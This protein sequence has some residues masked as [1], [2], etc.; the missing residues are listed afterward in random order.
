MSKKVN[1]KFYAIHFINDNENVIT[2]SWTECQELT[3]GRNNMFKGFM[4][5]EDAE[6]WLSQITPDQEERHNEMVKKNRIVKTM[7]QSQVQYA[8]RI[9][10][11][12]SD[13][14]QEKLDALH[15]SIDKL[16]ND[17]IYEYLYGEE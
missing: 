17:M 10:K 16:M 5:R 1:K 15:I 9:D 7:K 8:F 13:D 4:S 12:M 3:K 6:E 14:L 2:E 11:K